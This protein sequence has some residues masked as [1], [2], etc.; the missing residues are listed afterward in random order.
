MQ[1]GK[2]CLHTTGGSPTLISPI[3]SHSLLSADEVLTDA[4][5]ALILVVRF[6]R[7]ASLD[8]EG[9]ERTNYRPARTAACPFV[10]IGAGSPHSDAAANLA[11]CRSHSSGFELG[12]VVLVRYLPERMTAALTTQ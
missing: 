8:D 9:T 12:L 5:E 10:A 7:M 1:C 6:R 3:L 4:D 2:W 11:A